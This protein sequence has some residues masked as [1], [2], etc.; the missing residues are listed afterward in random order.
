MFEQETDKIIATVLQ[1]VPALEGKVAVKDILAGDIPPCVKTFFRADVE[2]MLLAELQTHRRSSRFDFRHPEVRTLQEQMNSVLVLHYAFPKEEFDR[3]LQDSVHLLVNY[4]V[5]PQWTIAGVVFE[6]DASIS[7][8]ALLGLLHYFSPYAYLR[9]IIARY[10]R[11]KEITSFT[12]G[13]FTQLL[14][15]VDGEFIRRKTGSEVARIMTPLFEFLDFPRNSGDKTLPV[16][17]VIKFF[18]DKGLTSAISQLEGEML[19][20]RSVVRQRE[21]GDLL[22]DVRRTCGAFE[23]QKVDRDQPALRGN[24]HGT[25]YSKTGGTD[26]GTASSPVIEFTIEESDRRRFVKKIFLQDEEGYQAALRSL[27]T[28]SSWKEASKFIDEIFIRNDINPYSSE[29][30]RFIEVIFGQYHP[31]Q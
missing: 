27:G 13:E 20:G 11:E 5:R 3:L 6:R 19:Q 2:S 14:W 17:G 9:E 22:E 24:G 25:E 29:A 10:V 8:Q 1:R 4:H 31:K 28:R 30:K 18:E 21:L 16:R 15:K 23:V 12:A 7:A 26:H